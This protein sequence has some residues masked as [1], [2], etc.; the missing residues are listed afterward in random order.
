LLAN[1]QPDRFRIKIWE[2]SAGLVI[3]DN[4]AG[5]GDNADLTDVTIVGGG[6]IVIQKAK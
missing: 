2:E 5:S 3:Y 6:S 1:G 4:Q